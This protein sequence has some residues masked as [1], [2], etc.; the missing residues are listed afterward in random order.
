MARERVDMSG[1]RV[2]S[3]ED[4]KQD[5]ETPDDLMASVEKRF[6]QVKFDLAAH[7]GNKKHARYFAPEVLIESFDPAKMNVELFVESMV[8]KGANLEK[9]Q[10]AM[11]SLEGR[12]GL[13]NVK[14]D[15]TEAYA[16]NALK[17]DW[18][19]LSM[20]FKDGD[21]PGLLWLNCEFGDVRTWAEKCQAEGKRGAN[22]VLL[23]PAMVGSNWYRD[24]IAGVSDVYHMN[25]R[26]SFDGRNVYPKDTM[27]SHFHGKSSGRVHVW[28]WKEN[29][30]YH[31]WKVA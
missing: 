25:G 22:I 17:Q 12:K 13:V 4:S 10:N 29:K 5:Y 18:A 21:A 27:L 15:D 16:L 7:R 19:L 11:K 31:E 20:K 14:N 23:T 1:P 8:A 6:G 26:V 30:V 2:T 24:L 3:G 9:V 28:K